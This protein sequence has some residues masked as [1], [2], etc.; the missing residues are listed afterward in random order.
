[1]DANQSDDRR[2]VEEPDAGV[3]PGSLPVE[4][5]DN[6]EPVLDPDVDEDEAGR[7]AAADVERREHHNRSHDDS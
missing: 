7:A 5:A 2:P 6:G 3:A 1:M 4:P